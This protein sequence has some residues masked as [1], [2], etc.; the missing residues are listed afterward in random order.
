MKDGALESPVTEKGNPSA[1]EVEPGRGLYSY[2]VTWL[3]SV[4]SACIIGAAWIY[5]HPS[6]RMVRVDVG[7]LLDEQKQSLAARIKPGMSE[8][9][10]KALFMSATEYANQV[11]DALDVVAKECGC[12]VVNTAAIVR[13][14]ETGDTSGIPDMT[15]RVRELLSKAKK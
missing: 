4:L 8:E 7:S 6:P 14:P 12:A 15:G 3:L 13:L 11:N 10:Q 1:A 9:E 5:T 2:V